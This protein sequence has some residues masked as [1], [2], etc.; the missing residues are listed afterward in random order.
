MEI[1]QNS[2]VIHGTTSTKGSFPAFLEATNA[3]GT[4]QKE[5]EF[6]VTD[7]DAWKYQLELNVTG[8]TQAVTVQQFPLLVEL[9]TSMDGFH[10]DQFSDTDGKDLRFLSA[11]KSRELAYE[12]IEWNP[13]VVLI[14]GFY[15]LN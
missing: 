9:N 10:Y 7:F 12:V 5:I 1:N 15:Y 3:A 2:G 13:K 6:I 14:F 8:Y 11:D 4:Y